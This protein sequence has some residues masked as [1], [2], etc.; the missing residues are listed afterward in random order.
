MD[1][2]FRGTFNKAQY[3]IGLKNTFDRN[4]PIGTAV[5]KDKMDRSDGLG[6]RGRGL[7]G[8]DNGSRGPAGMST[9]MVAF[10]KLARD[11]IMSPKNQDES[12]NVGYNSNANN[13]KSRDPSGTA[14]HQ[15]LHQ[16]MA[17][18]TVSGGH[19]GLER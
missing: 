14:I 17:T 6:E 9:G 19:S 2:K 10:G 8:R 7:P 16:R 1:S 3:D 4:A 11:N 15:S 18:T 13:R 12:R 5:F